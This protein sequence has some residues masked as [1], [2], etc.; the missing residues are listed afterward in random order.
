MTR[1]M[2][3]SRRFTNESYASM[4]IAA[5]HLQDGMINLADDQ[6]RIKANPVYLRNEIFPYDDLQI[7]Q[8]QVWLN[9]M[10]TNGTILLYQANGRDY[11]QFHNWW[12]YQSL[13]FARPSD[14]PAPEGWQDRIRCNGQYNIMLYYNWTKADGEPVEDTCDSTGKPLPFV[15]QLPRKNQGGRPSKQGKP[16][17]EKVDTFPPTFP[18]TFPAG[19]VIK[20]YDQDQD[21]QKEEKGEAT[22]DA[23]ANGAKAPALFDSLKDHPAIKAYHDLYHRYPSKPQMALIIEHD[24][25]IAAR[26]RAIRAWSLAGHKPTNVQGMLDWA[27]DPSR[28]EGASSSG[29]AA[30][31]STPAVSQRSYRPP[32]DIDPLLEWRD[33]KTDG[34]TP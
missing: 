13:Q 30:S 10:V 7:E 9:L 22:A 1:R 5:R 21:Q 14:Y 32:A 11:A 8:I 24:P 19:K 34:A 31:Y 3:D 18:A 6:G 15:D 27:F 2:L 29:K 28:F 26:V 16:E 23:L 33:S 17:V 20:D 12:E 25:P 4:P